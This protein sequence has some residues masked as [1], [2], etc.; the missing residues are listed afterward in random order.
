[1]KRR[2]FLIATAAAAGGLA[3]GYRLLD[4]THGASAQP[5]GLAARGEVLLGGWMK[6]G[7][8]DTV[9]V[10]VPHVDMGQ[11]SHTALAMMLAEELDAD[12]SR[13]RTEQ[14]PA[15]DAFANR[16]L[17]RGFVMS[18]RQ[19]P[20]LFDGVVDSA[21][22]M[23]ARY[24]KLQITGGS[25]AVRF[26]GQTGMRVAGAVARELLMQAAARRWNVPMQEL[27]TANGAVH[28]AASGRNARYGALAEAAAQ[29]PVP[30]KP[31]L[32]NAADFK[33]IGT[34]PPRLDIPGKVNGNLKYGIDISL[35]NMRYAAVTAAPVHGE[36]LVACDTGAALA[37][38]GVER[39][40]QLPDGVAVIAHG[41]WA[42]RK[43]LLALKPVFGDGGN[44]AVSSAGIER[45]HGDALLN[46]EASDDAK[47]LHEQ[48]DAPAQLAQD[49]TRMLDATYHVPFLHH[50][51][52]EPINFTAQFAAGNIYFWGGAQNLLWTRAE[53]AKLADVPMDKVT[54]FPMPLGGAFGRRS[55]PNMTNY[56]P[57]IVQ[58]G[59]EAS[60]YPVKMIWS[61]EEDFAQGAYRPALAS[62]IRAAL[63]D[64]G[65]PTAWLQSA[66]DTGGRPGAYLLPSAIP[67]QSIRAVPG[68]YHIRWGAWRSVAHTQHGFYTESFIDELAHAAG[69]DP[70]L[71]RRDLLPPGSQH[72][73]VLETAAQRAG[74]DKP[75]AAGHARGIA[76]VASFGSIVAEVVEVSLDA[77]RT[78][79][80][81]R[82]T[83]AVDC[84]GLV[85]PDTARQQV[86]GSIVMGLSAALAEQIT[87]RDGAVVQRNFH[88]Y[89]LLRMHQVPEIEI[90]FLTSGAPLGG[91][92]EP[93]VPPVAPALT[94]ALFA[95]T[96][97][98]IRALPVTRTAL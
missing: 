49:D 18:N 73:R 86:E 77:D 79:R 61:R 4:A 75:L 41:Y 47:V 17:A 22:G 68:A 42:A 93:A 53:L 14:A 85:H 97:K 95:L 1:M 94:N 96:G 88:D 89:P 19:I 27:H 80:I 15:D 90:H 7:R 28:H 63:A 55:L 81:H 2:S 78:P 40:V 46:V 57:Q 16:F 38:A 25:S 37:V 50:A 74:W 45:A 31:K 71:Y 66:I 58:I 44:R 35:P 83:A 51:A 65:R 82:V 5:E 34:S 48:G 21:F 91:L 24:M 13:V 30:S 12:W 87:I 10:Y 32:K 6:I 26:T 76:I 62:R 9:T 36:K 11:G 20:A 23:A 29:L 39:V 43:G 52:M 67:H 8:D 69:R 3:L 56:L 98:R 70:Y 84:G 92:G 60:P 64:D 54:L 72:R 59:R 33:L